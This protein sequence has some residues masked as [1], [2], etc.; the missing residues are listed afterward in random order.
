MGWIIFWERISSCRAGRRWAAT[1]QS[2]TGFE[3]ATPSGSAGSAFPSWKGSRSPG[4][5]GQHTQRWSSSLWKRGG[6]KT[7]YWTGFI[8]FKGF[9]P[10]LHIT[11][12]EWLKLCAK[13]K[14]FIAGMLSKKL[15]KWANQLKLFS[16]S[17]ANN[18]KNYWK[19]RLRTTSPKP[20][21]QSLQRLSGHLLY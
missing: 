15:S 1:V 17:L 3:R 7:S 16:G 5:S 19:K 14:G 6:K 20:R 12:A 13:S 4:E 9:F 10:A 11:L 2:P 8:Q 18:A 21:L